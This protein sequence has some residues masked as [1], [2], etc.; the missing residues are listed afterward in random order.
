MSCTNATVRRFCPVV[1]QGSFTRLMTTLSCLLGYFIGPYY[2][3]DSLD[4][5][6]FGLFS[7]HPLQTLTPDFIE[8][9]RI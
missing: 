4:V 1:D 5:I 9:D 7:L 3:C 6:E 8:G 2:H